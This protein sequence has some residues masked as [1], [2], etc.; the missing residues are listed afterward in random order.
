MMCFCC[1]LTPT[2][3]ASDNRMHEVS[4]RFRVQ[5]LVACPGRRRRSH[6]LLSCSQFSG[7]STQAK[8]KSVSI[9]E[10]IVQWRGEAG[11]GD[12][13]VHFRVHSLVACSGRRRMIVS[14]T[15]LNNLVYYIFLISII[16][17]LKWST[18]YQRNFF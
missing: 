3:T 13:S 11:E 4:V 7:V 14:K 9:F 2:Q 12:V 6:C 16:D 15:F 8:T 17:K 18:K 1:G 5:S 10:L